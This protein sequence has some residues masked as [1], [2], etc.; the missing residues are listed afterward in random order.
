MIHATSTIHSNRVEVLNACKYTQ[1]F[2]KEPQG[3]FLWRMHKFWKI[4]CAIWKDK[5]PIILLS[6]HAML[7]GLLKFY[8]NPVP[9]RKGAE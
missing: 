6:T 7:Q 1:A 8:V 2:N 5:K 3:S 9:C 4:A